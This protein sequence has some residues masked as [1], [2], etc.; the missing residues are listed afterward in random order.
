VNTRQGW[1]VKV[2][3]KARPP[4]PDYSVLGRAPAFTWLELKATDR[5]PHRSAWHC[6]AAGR[7]GDRRPAVRRAEPGHV[8]AS[9]LRGI[10][11]T[12]SK[13]KAADRRD[14]PAAAAHD[15]GIES[16]RLSHAP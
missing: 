10:V 4:S 3:L 7:P 5:P 12:L 9:A 11:L 2:S 8:P 16:L 6:A 14:G 15:R 1:S 13:T